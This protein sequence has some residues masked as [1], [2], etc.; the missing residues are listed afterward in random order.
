MQ[1][2]GGGIVV[3]AV[4]A[5]VVMTVRAVADGDR[6]QPA[7][8][9]HLTLLLFAKVSTAVRMRAGVGRAVSLVQAIS[10]TSATLGTHASATAGVEAELSAADIRV[11]GRK[12]SSLRHVCAHQVLG[13]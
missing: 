1:T 12:P 2:L 4:F 8:F 11:S 10:A 3:F 9:D 13:V 5:S 6:W 7:D